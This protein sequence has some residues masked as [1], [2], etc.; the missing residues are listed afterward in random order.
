MNYG[1]IGFGNLANA[2]YQ[3]LREQGDLSFA[4][5]SRHR[6]EVEIPFFEDMG[7]LVSFSD[8]IWLGIK[9][10]D[11]GEILSQLRTCDLSGKAIVSPV[12]GKSIAFIE[13]YLGGNK[14]IVRIMPNLAIAYKKSVTSFATNRPGN[15]TASD[16][17]SRLT[18]LGKAVELPESGFDLFTSVFGSGPA[19][20]LAFIQ[21]FKD[22][23]REFNLPGELA[24]ELL[25]MLAQGTVSYFSENQEK[26]SIEQLISNI[27][28][29]G[30]TT[31]AGLNY[32][33]EHRL[34]ALFEGVLEAAKNRSIE[35]R[36]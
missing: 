14:T 9:P 16:I 26:Y 34:G 23:M 3:G 35:M 7:S 29:K 2:V 6:K 10:Q 28:S 1:F 17:Y 36:G 24:D 27:T 18:K 19:F 25:L 5:F 20:I 21:I 8:V 15:E 12:A 4:Y 22:K 32:F 13:S 31:Q 11:L 33:G 30:G